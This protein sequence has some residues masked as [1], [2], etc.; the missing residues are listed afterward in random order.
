MN[1]A[2]KRLAQSSGRF[3]NVPARAIDDRRLPAPALLVLAALGTYGN[4]AGW[5]WPSIG[6][7]A[8]RLGKSRQ[9]VSRQI[10]VLTRLGY[11]AVRQQFRDN[12]SCTSNEYRIICDAELSAADNRLDGWQDEPEGEQRHVAPPQRHVAPPATSE[13]APILTTHMNVKSIRLKGTE[14]QALFD[15]FFKAY[16]SRGSASNPRK[17][18]NI[19][20]LK[21]VGSGADP[22][23]IIQGAVA[24]AARR[25]REI[26]AD[27]KRDNARFTP[28]ATTW[29]RQER[30]DDELAESVAPAVS[31]RAF[32]IA[33][34]GE[35][36]KTHGLQ[37][38]GRDAV[39]AKLRE[40]GLEARWPVRQ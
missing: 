22:E 31:G 35:F 38:A 23:R 10:G 27:P 15:R 1:A 20:F 18:A 34:Q 7:I 24:L 19:L 16:P 12:G 17:P 4:A 6:T 26:A 29:L 9:A 8:R 32:S 40:L 13:V 11:L 33:E 30:W 25:A 36:L 3:A 14:A 5:C 21:I 2:P 28:Q 37:G 39:R